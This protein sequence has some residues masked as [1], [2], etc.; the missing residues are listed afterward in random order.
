MLIEREQD[1]LRVNQ[2]IDPRT[3]DRVA[4]IAVSTAPPSSGV[5]GL[6]K[7]VR[8]KMS[9][10]I[11]DNLVM[12]NCAIHEGDTICYSANAT[13]QKVDFRLVVNSNPTHR[14]EE[15][16]DGS[17]THDSDVFG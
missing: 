16:S 10:R 1:K 3:K 2:L 6:Q 9:N 7:V 11:L 8:D 12:E 14:S 15:E 13:N 17:W 5:R 4:R